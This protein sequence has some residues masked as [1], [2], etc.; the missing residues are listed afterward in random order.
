[1][2]SLPLLRVYGQI[3]GQFDDTVSRL[4]S[5]IPVALSGAYKVFKGG[6]GGGGDLNVTFLKGSFL[7]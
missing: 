3:S 1:M 7:H 4:V 6:G 2:I 5:Q